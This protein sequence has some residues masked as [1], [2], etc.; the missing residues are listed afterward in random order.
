VAVRLVKIR[1]LGEPKM[2]I[3]E[4]VKKASPSVGEYLPLTTLSK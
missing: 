1:R 2:F 4:R 3:Q